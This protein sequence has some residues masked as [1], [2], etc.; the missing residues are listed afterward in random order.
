MKVAFQFTVQTIPVCFF[1]FLPSVVPF[2]FSAFIFSRPLVRLVISGGQ[3]VSLMVSLQNFQAIVLNTF[4][5]P[6]I[7]FF[8]VFLSKE[9]LAISHNFELKAFIFVTVV[10]SSVHPSLP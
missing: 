3:N 7:D 8:F 10:L 9:F 4:E 5:A 2:L 1:F 6:L